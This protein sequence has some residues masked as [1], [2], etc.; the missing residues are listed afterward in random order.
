MKK[1]DTLR[2]ISRKVFGSPDRWD[3]IRKLNGI[4][5]PRTVGKPG[6]KKGCVG[7]TLKMP[8]S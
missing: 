6:K 3:D 4:A 7:T 2:L 1:G 5:D 8:K